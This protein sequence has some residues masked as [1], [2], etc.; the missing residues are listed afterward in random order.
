M[1]S[2]NYTLSPCRWLL[3]LLL[4]AVLAASGAALAAG[5]GVHVSEAWVRETLPG[6]AVA[7][8]YVT[9]LS[10]RPARLLGVRS[11]L[12]R[13]AEIH[14][15]S[16]AQGVMR[17]RALDS[18][19]LPAG[20]PVHLTPSGLHVMLFDPVR[21]FK[22]GEQVPLELLLEVAGKPLRLALRVPVR[23]P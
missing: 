8:F 17:M 4:L 1:E 21:P 11:A 9:V 6:Q 19:E 2:R 15:M 22:A 13:R 23:A 16:M 14:S 7:G 10:E 20:V 18:L 5:P 3:F 12:A